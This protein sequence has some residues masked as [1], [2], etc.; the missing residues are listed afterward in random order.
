MEILRIDP[1]N[2]SAAA[3][4]KFCVAMP[5]ITKLHLSCGHDINKNGR[6]IRAIAANMHHLKSLSLSRWKVE[7]KAI[8]YLL[9]TED[10]TLGG[11]PELVHLDLW[12]TVSVDVK[13][14]KKIILALP[15]LRTLKNAFLIAA[16]GDFTEKEIGEDTARCLNSLYGRHHYDHT[17]DTYS[18]ICYNNLAKSPV[19]QRFN[20]NIT[21][22]EIDLPVNVD[23]QK[24]FKLLTN[25]LMSMP[26]LRSVT[27]GAIPEGHDHVLPLLESIGD[28]LEQLHLSDL[29]G[30]PSI[31]VDDIM[32]T[33]RNL[34][35]FSLN[36]RRFENANKPLQNWIQKSSKL[37]V[38]NNLTEL[39]IRNMNKEMCSEDM[40]M[41]LLQSH[42]LN[43]ITIENIEAMSDDVMFQAL[44]S[45]GDAAL[46]KVTKFI[47]KNCPLITAAPLVH[48]LNKEN[49]SLEYLHFALRDIDNKVLT[50]A[51]RKYLKVLIVEKGF[52]L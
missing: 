46:S 9:P 30:H 19:L 49:C 14:L 23:G 42:W 13:L 48:W 50:D 18:H 37:P 43:K 20:N 39:N 47:I 29:C 17:D 36:Y 41:A 3:L 34:I 44:S 11:C 51:A 31:H 35:K 27:L 38:L 40:L 8:E 4:E 24:E 32:R 22:V 52:F 10:N 1:M 25:I 5:H 6:V 2:T 7:S 16:L 45:R 33:C 26:K 12:S 28:H 21:A 15:K